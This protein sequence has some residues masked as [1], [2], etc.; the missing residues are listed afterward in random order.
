V[1]LIGE[2]PGTSKDLTGTPRLAR[3][4]AAV[5]RKPAIDDHLKTG[6]RYNTV[7]DVGRQISLGWA[8]LSFTFIVLV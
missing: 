6:Q 2:G 7:Q 1:G 4:V 5:Y 3:N 8:S